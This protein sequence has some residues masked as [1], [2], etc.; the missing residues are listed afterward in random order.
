MPHDAICYS[1]P[2]FSW[3]VCSHKNDGFLFFLLLFCSK[4]PSQQEGALRLDDH[5]DGFWF[6]ESRDSSGT[7][8][9]KG[10]R[11]RYTGMCPPDELHRYE[12]MR[13]KNTITHIDHRGARTKHV[14]C[15]GTK[16][17]ES[18]CS[19]QSFRNEMESSQIRL[20]LFFL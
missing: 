13:R 14:N 19:F 18:M 7:C 20:V 3:E 6:E 8:W 11:V 12:K 4:K 5:L 9:P 2:I 15:R 10:T 16:S 17:T 1:R